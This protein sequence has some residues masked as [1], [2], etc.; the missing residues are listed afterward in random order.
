LESTAADPDYVAAQKKPP[1]ERPFH[2]FGDQDALTALLGSVEFA[3]VPVAIFDAA[4]TLPIPAA[5]A[6][7]R[8]ASASPDC[9]T[10]SLCSSTPNGRNPGSSWT[11]SMTACKAA[12]GFPSNHF[13]SLALR[14]GGQ[15]LS[16]SLGGDA[17][18]SWMEYSS[19]PGGFCGYWG[20]A[21]SRCA[22]CR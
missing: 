4:G 16:E 14:R 9:F 18:T 17:K 11:L 12:S 1:H 20:S 21:I 3:E 22:D 13:G 19:F 2:F 10:A 6:P 15:D 5:R 8:S 7:M